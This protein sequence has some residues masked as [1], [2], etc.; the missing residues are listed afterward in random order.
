ML[1]FPKRRFHYAV[2][3][4]LWGHRS[5]IEPSSLVFLLLFQCR[6]WLQSRWRQGGLL[7][8]SPPVGFSRAGSRFR[9]E[10]LQSQTPT[11]ILSSCMP[12]RP[13]R[14]LCSCSASLARDL[15]HGA[16]FKLHFQ[17]ICRYFRHALCKLQGWSTA[18]WGRAFF[19]NIHWAPGPVTGTL[20]YISKNIISH[21][22]PVSPR[23]TA[24]RD[25]TLTISCSLPLLSHGRLFFC[26]WTLLLL[27]LFVR[28]AWHDPNHLK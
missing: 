6:L 2:W 3:S 7:P 4:D 8:L 13:R 27:L 23:R 5:P 15:F 12:M 22:H 17:L 11:G 19:A 10:A 18:M 20:L 1:K 24:A 26:I 16:T 9:Y 14:P 21:A 28:T 25:G